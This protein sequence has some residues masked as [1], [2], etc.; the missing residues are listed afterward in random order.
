[1]RVAAI[2]MA[3]SQLEFHWLPDPGFLIQ[4]FLI[5]GPHR[6]EVR[7]GEVAGGTGTGP[8]RR[9]RSLHCGFLAKRRA[10]GGKS[11]LSGWAK[12]VERFGSGHVGGFGSDS[13]EYCPFGGNQEHNTSERERHPLAGG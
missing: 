9:G 3:D 12:S 2:P 10:L 5:Q 8:S 1:M 4:G 11:K 7:E 13:V 6:A